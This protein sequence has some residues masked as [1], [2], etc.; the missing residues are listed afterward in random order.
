MSSPQSTLATLRQRAQL[1]EANTTERRRSLLFTMAI[2]TGFLGI[3]ATSAVLTS[4]QHLPTVAVLS[5][6]SGVA[7][8]FAGFLFA[9]KFDTLTDDEEFLWQV[10]GP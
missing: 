6:L 9:G 5:V 1:F 7:F 10:F 3:A 2:A 4:V 8:V